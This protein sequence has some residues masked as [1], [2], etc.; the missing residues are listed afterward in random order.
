MPKKIRF[1]LEYSF[2]YLKSYAFAIIGGILFGSIIFTQR[3]NLSEIYSIIQP[4]T[5]KIGI[6]GLYTIQTLPEDISHK[7]SYGLSITSENER[8]SISPIVDSLE[9]KDDNKTYLFTLK[10]G[11]LWHNQK[12]LEADDI[13]INIPGTTSKAIS[14]YQL[15]I[16]APEVFSP[17]LSKLNEP[18]FFKKTNVGLGSYKV[19]KISYRD[20]Y[21]KILSLVPIDTKEDRLTYY[22]YNNS[23]DLINAFKL[24]EVH[25]ISTD[26]LNEELSKWPNTKLS[27]SIPTD[28]YIALFI[29]TDKIGNKQLRQAIAYATPKTTDKNTRCL[30]PIS[31]NSW[32]Y[33]PQVKEY[34]FNVT[35]AKELF[36]K[37]KIEQL[38]LMVADRQLMGMAEEIKKSWSETFN[39]SV[40][41]T[42]RHQQANLL[43][44]QTILAFGQIPVDPDQYIFWH[45]TQKNTN[46]THFDNSRIDKLLEDG[47]LSFDQQ[48]RKNIYYDFQR[49]LLEES[50]VVFLE[51]PTTYTISRLK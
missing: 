12:E 9:M 29:N 23:T 30:S 20:G 34:R 28:Q 49:F 19:D 3:Q 44:Y 47:R 50:P 41:I 48:E 46:I 36:E 18:I 14:P 2:H 37:N 25:Q 8:S 22:F 17:L 15:E 26:Q 51:F 35:R 24:G 10:K 11:I 5:Q 33:N 45:S 1:F 39:I 6:E 32:A 7:I 16:K 40:K 13:E 27:S 38:E 21:I 43:D 31:P 4:R 42:L